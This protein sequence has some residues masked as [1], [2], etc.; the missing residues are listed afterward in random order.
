MEEKAKNGV[1]V[2]ALQFY[3]S[4][5]SKIKY[6]QKVCWYNSDKSDVKC[7]DAK[8]K[9]SE[10]NDFYY[11]VT[12]LGGL[13]EKIV[14]GNYV[15]NLDDGGPRADY[16]VSNF[17][18]AYAILNELEYNAAS[19]SQFEDSSRHFKVSG[20]TA[21]KAAYNSAKKRVSKVDKYSSFYV[22]K[23]EVG[24]F[25][26]YLRQC[27]K[28]EEKSKE[29]ILNGTAKYRL[30]KEDEEDDDFCICSGSQVSFDQV[31]RIIAMNYK[32]FNKGELPSSVKKYVTNYMRSEIKDCWVVASDDE[33]LTYLL[34]PL[35]LSQLIIQIC[36]I[37]FCVGGGLIG[38]FF[39]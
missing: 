4:G 18:F 13:T 38:V 27:G 33:N 7:K 9:E 37:L 14:V 32:G 15:D 22:A 23:S 28:V 21:V 12:D 10:F 29:E 39:S 19:G 11:T 25:D 16:E 34:Y 26:D 6:Y 20:K 17:P 30:K 3:H 35:A 2:A 24:D 1:K 8:V 31:Y 36:G 5:G